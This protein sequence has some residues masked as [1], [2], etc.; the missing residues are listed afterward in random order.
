MGSIYIPR[1]RDGKWIYD[2]N[3]WKVAVSNRS[4]SQ[5]EAGQHLS[6]F[7]PAIQRLILSY[8]KEKGYVVGKS[9]FRTESAKYKL[10]DKER[11]FGKANGDGQREVERVIELGLCN[12]YRQRDEIN[13]MYFLDL[14]KSMPVWPWPFKRKSTHGFFS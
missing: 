8:L 10:K 13:I 9:E 12:D 6:T 3:S 11:W 14:E 5:E 2:E 4:P 1:W 7:S